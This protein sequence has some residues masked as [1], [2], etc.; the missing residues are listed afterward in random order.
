MQ[1]TGHYYDEAIQK[2]NPL[3]EIINRRGTNSLKW[4]V[5]PHV[6]PM[7]VADMDFKTA[8]EIMQ[9]VTR[10]AMHGIYGYSIVPDEWYNAYISWWGSRYG[11]S[12][13]KDWILFSNGVIP[14]ISCMI[15]ALSKV[16]EKI[17][18]QTPV[19]NH[20]YSAI[21]AN[22]RKISENKLLYDGESFTIDWKDLEEKLSDSDTSIFLLCNP[23]NPTGNLWDSET[24]SRIADMAKANSVTVISDEIHCDIVA[25]SKRYIP[26]ASVSDIAG[27]ISVTAVSPSKTFNISGLQ[28]S[29]I[30]CADTGMRKKI[31][32]SMDSL[33]INL[34]NAFA[35]QSA[36]T[37]YTKCG[38][39][40]DS[41]LDYLFENRR[42]AESFIQENIPSAKA[43]KADATYLLWIDISGI[44]PENRDKTR[45]LHKFLIDKE[46]LFLSEGKIFGESAALFLRMNLAC[47]KDIMMEGLS[48]LKS[49][50]QHFIESEDN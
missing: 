24:L 50:I 44:L 7:W 39:W 10:R 6:L 1:K 38:K 23:H 36:V 41:L 14:S 12:L 29:A 18:I 33:E 20:F 19:Y 46:G 16:G 31:S 32:D 17:L 26:F 3:N 25:P 9:A 42:I 34:P 35:V 22:D 45:K 30:F 49:G 4:D 27:E 13:E 43:V 21:L 5:Y 15:R 37:A 48:K 47:P 11:L 8:P 28:S 2:F 40:L